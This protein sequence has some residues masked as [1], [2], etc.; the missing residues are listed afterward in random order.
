MKALQSNH[1]IRNCSRRD[2][3]SFGKS[4]CAAASN[5]LIL[6]SNQGVFRRD[7]IRRVC[8]HGGHSRIF[9]QRLLSRETAV[10]G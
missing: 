3:P 1:I 4:C 6:S 5:S 9:I 2:T 8:P 10:R 7:S